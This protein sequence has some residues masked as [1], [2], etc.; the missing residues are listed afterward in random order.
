MAEG[1][2]Y[3]FN[4]LSAVTILE[5]LFGLRVF[6]SLIVHLAA[7]YFFYFFSANPKILFQK[8]S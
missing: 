2:V 1:W 6:S 8:S 4:I 3:V 7:N 5:F